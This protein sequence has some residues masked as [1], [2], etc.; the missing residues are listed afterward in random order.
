[1]QL[2]GVLSGGSVARSVLSWILM[3]MLLLHMGIGLK[4]TWDTITACRKSG[5][6]YFRENKVFWARRLSGFAVFVLIFFHVVLF[7]GKN[8]DAYRLRFFGGL[9]L[10][11]QILLVVAV[12]LHII[13]N[14]KPLWIAFGRKSLKE[15]A[16]DIL[17]IL[18]VLLLFM[19]FAFLVYYIRWNRI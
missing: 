13:T 2:A 7:M 10:A 11:T 8:G 15:Y 4:L 19:G 3:A 5:V 1:F 14:V 6:S 17:I 12:G 16:A 9:Q 18:S